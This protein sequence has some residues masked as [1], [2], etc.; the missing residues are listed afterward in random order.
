MVLEITI[1]LIY[2][3]PLPIHEQQQTSPVRSNKPSSSSCQRQRSKAVAT[4]KLP[5]LSNG[6]R[7]EQ[8][9]TTEM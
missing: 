5:E 4:G 3:H 2:H 1:S 8:H 6:I 9:I 7:L